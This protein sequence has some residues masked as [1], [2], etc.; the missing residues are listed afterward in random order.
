MTPAGWQMAKGSGQLLAVPRLSLCSS[1]TIDLSLLT[2]LSATADPC[3]LYP[4]PASLSSRLLRS[5]AVFRRRF[6]SAFTS[7]T[8]N[9]QQHIVQFVS[10]LDELQNTALSVH[11]V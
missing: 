6:G 11:Q 8:K 3:Q 9:M 7:K 5:D 10:E 4:Q 2:F 1:T